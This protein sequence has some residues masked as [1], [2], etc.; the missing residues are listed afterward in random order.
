[1]I[2]ANLKEAT[3]INEYQ[4]SL[5]QQLQKAHGEQYTDYLDEIARLTKNAQ[6]Y[7]EIGTF[8][9]ASTSTAMMNMIPY[10]ETI[11][12][13]FVH[14]NPHKHIFETHAQQNKIETIIRV[15]NSSSIRR[16]NHYLSV[17]VASVYNFVY[18]LAH[19]LRN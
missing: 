16:I 2:V 3:N 15:T 14:I 17:C 9:G 10:I 12:L 1:M 18:R 4:I 13:D 8:Q 5:K 19:F 11:D 6:S 7:R